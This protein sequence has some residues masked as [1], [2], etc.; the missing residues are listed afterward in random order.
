MV[1]HALKIVHITSRSVLRVGAVTA[2]RHDAAASGVLPRCRAV[3]L[4]AAAS[5]W[6]SRWP[7][8]SAAA[9]TRPVQAAAAQRLG[10]IRPCA[11]SLPPPLR[12]VCVQA[13]GTPASTSA[14]VHSLFLVLLHLSPTASIGVTT[15]SSWS[16][17]SDV[18][19]RPCTA[20]GTGSPLASCPSSDS[21]HRHP[22]LAT[23]S[24]PRTTAPPLPRSFRRR[25]GR[26]TAKHRLKA[27]R[28]WPAFLSR[29]PPQ[30]ARRPSSLGVSGAHRSPH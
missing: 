12:R 25:R 26:A 28:T 1:I 17:P 15:G 3:P 10:L 18:P 6:P 9:A 2:S 19:L 11:L 23:L 4:A 29:P 27:D 8:R 5:S 24:A 14:R 21:S 13:E 7:G 30:L 20:M 16:F 22:C